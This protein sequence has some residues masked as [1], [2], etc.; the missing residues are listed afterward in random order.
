MYTPYAYVYVH[1][2]PGYA[3]NHS[4]QR[5]L[6]SK[7]LLVSPP[8]RGRRRLCGRA[9]CTCYVHVVYV[10]MYVYVYLYLHVH[11]CACVNTYI[12]IYIYVYVNL[13]TRCTCICMCICACMCICVCICIGIG[14]GISM[15]MCMPVKSPVCCGAIQ[16][17]MGICRT[18]KLHHN[19]AERLRR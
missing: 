16:S 2:S 8:V 17:S 13:V 19:V 3:K 15:C 1:I 11:V 18:R 4:C 9:V 6:V 5:G 7:E 10:N 12:Y 14:I